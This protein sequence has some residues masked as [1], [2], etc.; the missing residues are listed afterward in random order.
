MVGVNIKNKKPI[1]LITLLFETASFYVTLSTLKLSVDQADLELRD[2]SSSDSQLLGLKACATML[3]PN[4]LSNSS[5]SE[6]LFQG[7]KQTEK[8]RKCLYSDQ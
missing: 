5:I 4:M 6:G 2:P 1:N 3:T 8:Q 7:G